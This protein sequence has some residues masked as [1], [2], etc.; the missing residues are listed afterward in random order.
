MLNNLHLTKY[1]KLAQRL[2]DPSFKLIVLQMSTS[3]YKHKLISA[4]CISYEE[5][6]KILNQEHTEFLERSMFSFRE[7][8]PRACSLLADCMSIILVNIY[9]RHL[10]IIPTTNLGRIIEKTWLLTDA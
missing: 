1:G 8:D 2:R 6:R 4:L 7:F 10:E 3:Y 9:C 5:M